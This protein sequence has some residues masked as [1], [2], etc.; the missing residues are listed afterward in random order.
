MHHVD[1]RVMSGGGQAAG[2]NDVPIQ[3]GA[4]RV[5]DRFVEVVA[6]H[7]NGE[8][9]GD[10]AFLKISRALQDARQQI[11]DRRRVA[12]LAGRLAGGQ[13]DLALGH[14]Q[15]GHRI[16]DE[17]ARWRP[18]RENTRRSPGPRNRRARVAGRDGRRWRRPPPSGCCPPVRVPVRE[19]R[20]LRGCVRR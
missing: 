10:G 3:D 19:T 11:E 14:G 18:G 5:A 20:G 16:H 1:R 4:Y 17:A 2:K 9:A 8:E 7:Q 12:F 13:P 15:A 6:F